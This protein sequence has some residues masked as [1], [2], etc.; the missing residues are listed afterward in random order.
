MT[1]GFKQEIAGKPNFFIEKIWAAISPNGNMIGEYIKYRDEY[2]AK[3]G[4]AW[5]FYSPNQDPFE[6]GL[7]PFHEKNHTIR[8]DPQNRWKAGKLI[9]PVVN[10]RTAKRFQFAPVMECKST[11]RIDIIADSMKPEIR[12]DGELFYYWDCEI[13]VNYAGLH[14]LAVND[15]F[16]NVGDFLNYFSKGV[17]DGKIIHWTD[18]K[19]QNEQVI[20]P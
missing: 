13:E 14:K 7:P 18:M 15:G 3:F 12:I 4:K 16:N 17:T 11:Q 20:Y 19:Y 6:L 10:N 8:T 1:L 5:D 2:E 9:H